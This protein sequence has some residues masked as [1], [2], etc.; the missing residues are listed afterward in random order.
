MSGS[1]RNYSLP[2]R[3]ARAILGFLIGCL[4]AC[5][6]A[7]ASFRYIL[8]S[9]SEFALAQSEHIR[10]PRYFADSDADPD[11]FKLREIWSDVPPAEK[12]NPRDPKLGWLNS[13]IRTPNYR[14]AQ[15]QGIGDRRPF[16]FYG[17]SFT[18]CVMPP[19]HCW[20]GLLANTPLGNE[21]HLLNYG[22]RAFGFGQ[23]NLLFEESIDQWM[24]RK[25]IVAIGI[26][27]DNDLD[28][29]IFNFRGAP[30][31]RYKIEDGQL[32]VEL[33][34]EYDIAEWLADN[35]PN[36]SSYVIRYLTCRTNFLPDDWNPPR[37][38]D[39]TIVA[40]KKELNLAVLE[41]LHQSLE[42][43]DLDYFFVLFFGPKSWRREKPTGWRENFIIDALDSLGIPWV[44]SRNA[45]RASITK[46]VGKNGKPPEGGL[47]F[48]GDPTTAGHFT[49]AGNLAALPAITQG[50]LGQYDGLVKERDTRIELQPAKPATDEHSQ[51]QTEQT[52][53]SAPCD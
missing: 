5:A 40:R 37:S 15:A 53:T 8:F 34:G 29:T 42:S 45:M 35:P 47:F 4:L 19:K 23:T 14:H 51:T 52:E 24:P 11:Y 50:L 39:P 43:R 48:M 17:D 36:I 21:V 9:D 2:L 28:R 27:V 3:I 20:E 44:S 13:K 30:K 31:P 7:E 46:Y 26:L 33:P 38:N 12:F 6:T 22:V 32:A 1:T 18:A 16:L 25:P 10:I 49:R 41:S